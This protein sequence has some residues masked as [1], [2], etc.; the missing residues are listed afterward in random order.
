VA[1]SSRSTGDSRLDAEAARAQSVVLLELGAELLVT[2]R[3]PEGREA[4]HRSRLMS[5]MLGARDE[6]AVT[7]HGCAAAQRGRWNRDHSSELCPYMAVA[8]A[9]SASID[10]RVAAPLL[11]QERLSDSGWWH[12]ASSARARCLVTGRG[13]RKI[14]ALA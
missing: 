10:V 9:G 6:I 5:S 11:P 12:E 1:R 7:S 14:A 4:K 2:S 3:P 13:S 8:L